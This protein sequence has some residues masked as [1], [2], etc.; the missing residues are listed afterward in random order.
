MVSFEKS[1]E[2]AIFTRNELSGKLKE[3]SLNTI[4]VES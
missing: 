4:Y 3:G 1:R 2:N